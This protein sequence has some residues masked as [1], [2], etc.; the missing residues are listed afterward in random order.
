MLSPSENLPPSV[1]W[2]WTA[3]CQHCLLQHLLNCSAM[4]V[5]LNREKWFNGIVFLHCLFH[6]RIHC[7]C[8]DCWTAMWNVCLIQ[9]QEEFQ[10]L[11]EKKKKEEGGVSTTVL[12]S[13]NRSEQPLIRHAGEGLMLLFISVAVTSSWVLLPVGFQSWHRSL[14]MQMIKV[15]A[16]LLSH[17]HFPITSWSTA[18]KSRWLCPHVTS[19]SQL[20]LCSSPSG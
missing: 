10:T 1:F 18:L 15:W 14:I 13:G 7:R 9:M 12:C 4:T 6:A 20:Y 3:R 19:L 11:K 8:V 17:F 2:C 5:T 16:K